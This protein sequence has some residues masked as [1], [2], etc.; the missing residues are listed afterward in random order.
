MRKDDKEILH[1]IN[2]AEIKIIKKIKNDFFSL[3][4]T[5][6][7]RMIEKEEDKQKRKYNKKG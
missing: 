4:S 1:I 7:C 2:R 6:G 3:K 5:I